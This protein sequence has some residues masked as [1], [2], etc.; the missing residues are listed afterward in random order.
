ME[1][2]IDASYRQVMKKIEFNGNFLNIPGAQPGAC[3]AAWCHGITA[4]ESSPP[5][6]S[7]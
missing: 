4:V 6:Q 5:V 7:G 1:S 3:P 2:E